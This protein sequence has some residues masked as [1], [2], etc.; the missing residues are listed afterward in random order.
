MTG[1]IV[2]FLTVLRLGRRL[3]E[4]VQRNEG[5]RAELTEVLAAAR[6]EPASMLNQIV[7]GGLDGRE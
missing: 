1:H 3:T 2:N 7:E 4:A 6:E 5:A